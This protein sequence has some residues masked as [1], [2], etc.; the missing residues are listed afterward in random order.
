MS[1][2]VLFALVP[3]ASAAPEHPMVPVLVEQI[4]RNRAR[5]SLPEAPPIYHL[6]YQ[7]L[8]LEQVDVLASLGGLVR[9]SLSPYNLLAVEVRVGEPSYDNTGFGGWQDGFRRV[10]LPKELT[11]ESLK[12]ELWRTTDTAYK[13]AVE[14]Y[15]RKVSQFVAPPDYPGDYTLT[16]AVVAD[17]GV[18]TA[19]QSEETLKELALAMTA[20]LAKDPVVVRGEVYIGHEAGSML[21][22]DSEGTAVRSPVEET[23]VRALVTARAADGMLVSAERLWTV[24][25]VTDLPPREQMIAEVTALRAELDA[26][27]AAPALSE[28]YVGPVVLEGSAAADLFRYVLLSQLEGTP[29]DVPFDSMFGELGENKDPVRLGRRVL[30]PGFTVVDDPLRWQTHP[31][32]YRHDNEGTETR[33][34]ELVSDGIVKDVAMSRVPRKGIGASNGHARG[35]MGQRASGRVTMLDVVSERDK[36]ESKL[37]KTAFK[38]ARAYGRDWVLAVRQLQEPCVLALDSDLFWDE[39]VSLPPPVAV[40]KRYSDGREELLRGATFAAVERWVLR[41]IVLAGPS[42][43]HDYLSPP[44]GNDWAGLAPTE[45]IASRIRAP[46]VLVGEIEI[47]PAAADP[48]ELPVLSPPTASR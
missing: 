34:I 20:A 44:S 30:P 18:G 8:E 5:L 27:L 37:Y 14:Q 33:A 47:V 19:A 25:K 21:T 17:D 39:G 36:P 11:P 32:S 40:V 10:G 16:G 6:R 23:S 24:R 12:L 7:L 48:R 29:A 2:H 45:G 42:S 28:E 9:A 35:T 41:D 31:G 38:L 3:S 43:E 15:A 22:V 46:S 1:L 26:T 13:E 4:E